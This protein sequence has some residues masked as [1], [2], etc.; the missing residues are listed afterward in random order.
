MLRLQAQFIV[1]FERT[2]PLP[3]T[4][5]VAIH[6]AGHNELA[7]CNEPIP[8]TKKVSDFLA[9]INDSSLEAGITC[10]LSDDRYSDSFESTQQFLGTLVANQMIHRQGRKGTS[11]ERN[12]SSTEGGGNK[13]IK[14]GKAT[15]KKRVAARF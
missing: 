2:S 12:V 4:R 3:S 15:K 7:D 1:G 13:N 10:V 9:G 5:Y 6:Q 8:E 14:S 11:D